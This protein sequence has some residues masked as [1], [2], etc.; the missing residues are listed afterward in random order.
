MRTHKKSFTL[1]EMVII[2]II[3]SVLS[4]ALIPRLMSVQARARDLQRKVDVKQLSNGL[5]IYKVDRGSYPTGAHLTNDFGLGKSMPLVPVYF[6]S[7]PMD[8]LI[9]PY[10]TN[11]WDVPMLDWLIST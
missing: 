4:A 8:P 1:I 11:I 3:I 7:I 2:L 5:A 10:N 9:T 6:T